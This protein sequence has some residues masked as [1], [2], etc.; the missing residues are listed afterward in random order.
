VAGP[1]LTFRVRAA[2]A[3]RYGLTPS[4]IAAAVEA[5]KLGQTA[6][7]VLATH[8]V[9]QI[10]V[11]LNPATVGRIETLKN[12]PLRTAESQI[13]ASARSPTCERSRGSSSCLRRSKTMIT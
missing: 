10:G 11:M 8:R 4:D 9:S 13:V 1:S 7:Y 6:P 5:A 2:D 3:A 12:L